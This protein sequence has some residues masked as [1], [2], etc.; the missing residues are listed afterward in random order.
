MRWWGDSGDFVD[1]CVRRIESRQEWLDD[2]LAC[3]MSGPAIGMLGRWPVVALV[4]LQARHGCLR[5]DADQ[6]MG[7]WAGTLEALSGQG[8]A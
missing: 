7:K 5:A 6:L 2:A 4:R 3:E 8:E 1:A